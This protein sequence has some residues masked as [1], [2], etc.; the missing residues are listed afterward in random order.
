MKSVFE[1]AGVTK[2]LVT[3]DA[4]GDITVE[5]DEAENED[6]NTD[7]IKQNFEYP[8]E[9][10]QTFRKILFG[11]SPQYLRLSGEKRNDVSCM[12]YTGW[13]LNHIYGIK[14]E[15]LSVAE[16]GSIV[17]LTDEVYNDYDYT[18]QTD[19]YINVRKLV[20][21]GGS[22]EDEVGRMMYDNGNIYLL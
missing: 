8:A 9:T 2:A 15:D 17:G 10:A 5:T 12:Y 18:P 13:I 14:V 7:V 1:E 4:K 6:V 21:R 16:D 19:F 20:A 22:S 3:V 11:E